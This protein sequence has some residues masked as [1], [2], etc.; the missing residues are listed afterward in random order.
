LCKSV[1]GAIMPIP[2]GVGTNLSQAQQQLPRV[3][4]TGFYHGVG[5]SMAIRL[6]PFVVD[7]NSCHFLWYGVVAGE[8]LRSVGANGDPPHPRAC[9]LSCPS[10]VIYGPGLAGAPAFIL[11]LA[12]H[13]GT[14][15]PWR[16][17]HLA[18]LCV[19]RDRRWCDHVY[20]RWRGHTQANKPAYSSHRLLS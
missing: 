8:G 14:S 11:P 7:R 18:P 1:C 13:F 9:A 2:G 15:P 6:R 10:P 3:R 19:A 5:A 20:P 17:L 16:G 4:R 12:A